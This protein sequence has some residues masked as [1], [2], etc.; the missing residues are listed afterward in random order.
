MPW[1]PHLLYCF[2]RA[3]FPFNKGGSQYLILF[4]WTCLNSRISVSVLVLPFIIE[5]RI[6]WFCFCVAV[7]TCKSPVFL[8]FASY[9]AIFYPIFPWNIF[10]YN[11]KYT[12]GNHYKQCLTLD[13]IVF[14]DKPFEIE[15]IPQNKY[16]CWII[17]H[18]TWSINCL[19][20]SV[21]FITRVKIVKS[22]NFK[23]KN[24][25]TRNNYKTAICIFTFNPI[26]DGG[27][28]VPATN[29]SC[30]TSAKV[31]IRPPKLSGFYF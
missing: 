20:F 8:V 18:H 4:W 10:T 9:H 17:V 22:S 24:V 14:H 29:F 27:G 21:G 19:W 15:I 12:E 7:G 2:D 31:G 13:S 11:K 3:H 26:Q 23:L 1:Y 5:F 16:L 6:W 30:V 25:A 28:E